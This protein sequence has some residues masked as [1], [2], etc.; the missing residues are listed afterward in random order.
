MTTTTPSPSTA[1]T[2]EV[3]A[4]VELGIAKSF[5]AVVLVTR[6]KSNGG[7]RWRPW[8]MAAALMTMAL[9][10]QCCRPSLFFVQSQKC[11]VVARR[12]SR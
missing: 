7:C 11:A 10:V 4:T 8:V 9:V 6:L 3:R 12:L 1:A 2:T 5:A